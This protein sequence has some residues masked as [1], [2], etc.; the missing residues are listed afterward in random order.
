M[1]SL[2]EM[3]ELLREDMANIHSSWK[4]NIDDMHLDMPDESST[5]LNKES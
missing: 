5:T 4:E 1:N 3:I 2:V